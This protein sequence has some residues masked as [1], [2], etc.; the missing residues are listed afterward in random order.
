MKKV[1]INK[2]GILESPY[3][4][5]AIIEI[6]NSDEEYDKISIMPF[7]K[8]WKLNN[9]GNSFYL[10]DLLTIEELKNRR[11]RECF[12]IV[13]NRSPMW[14]NNLSEQ[15]KQELNAWYQAWL[16]VTTTKIIPIKPEWL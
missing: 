12:R 15:Q 10:I 4:K 1:F 16:N 2:D 14:Y 6:N 13:D 7:H 5:D 8:N 9:D 11:E 3:I